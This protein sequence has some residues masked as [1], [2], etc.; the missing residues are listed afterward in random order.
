MD[1]NP[2][3]PL[4]STSWLAAHLDAPDVRIVDA[5]WFMPG[6]DRDA[7]AEF[8]A[9]HIPGAVFFDIDEIA[10]TDSPLPHMLPSTMKFAARV[11]KLGLGDGARIVVYDSSGILGAARVWWTFRV[12]GH[13]DVVVLD[14]GLPRWLA[15][16]RPVD[17]R[18]PSPQPRHF[19]PRLAGDLVC[20]LAQ[21]RRTVE[22]GRAQII[23]ARPAGRFTGEVP[24]PRVGLRSGH[25]PG[26][27]S[28]PAGSVF[29]A[30][31]TLKS[32]DDLTA[33]FT[34]AGIDLKKP[35]VTTCGSGITASLLALALARIGRPRTTVYDG[36]W[37]EWGG[38]EDTPVVTGA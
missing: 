13:E 19:T 36:S 4:V 34:G 21:M 2:T 31:G 9:A 15:E 28:V 38:R 12:M 6:T 3:D 18:L 16:G 35:I 5:S 20:D 32:A 30:D 37:T 8:A 14:G 25:M 33:L 10:D 26:A 11:Q 24:E 7:K 29:A 23:D 27:R 22:T 17:D 1:R